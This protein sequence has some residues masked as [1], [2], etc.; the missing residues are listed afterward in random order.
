M[1][2]L[3]WTFKFPAPLMR[4]PLLLPLPLP[5]VPLTLTLPLAAMSLSRVGTRALLRAVPEP[6]AARIVLPTLPLLCG[7]LASQPAQGDEGANAPRQPPPR[8]ASASRLPPLRLGGGVA[9]RR[10]ALT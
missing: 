1:A 10:G 8:P 2:S 5:L 6:E 9:R 7:S 4:V 3:K